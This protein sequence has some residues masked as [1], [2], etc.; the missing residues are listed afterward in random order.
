LISFINWVGG[1]FVN[2]VKE[3]VD[4]YVDERQIRESYGDEYA[5][6]FSQVDPA[7]GKKR[8]S[9]AKVLTRVVIAGL[10]AFWII[11]FIRYKTTF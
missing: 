7:T 10:A 8:I 2:R 9:A 6:R 1:F 4:I 5:D 11:I 3:F